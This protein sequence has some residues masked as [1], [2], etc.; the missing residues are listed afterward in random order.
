MVCVHFVL[1]LPIFGICCLLAKTIPT[2]TA[3]K[4]K[5]KIFMIDHDSCILKSITVTDQLIHL[6]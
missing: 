2:F 5:I 3:F 1:L 6:Y 4:S